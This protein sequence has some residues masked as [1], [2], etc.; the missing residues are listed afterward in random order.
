MLG[1]MMID[2]DRAATLRDEIGAE[3]FAEVVDMFIDEMEAEFA[4]LR[5]AAR[6]DRLEA[7]LH[8]LKGSALNLGF[9]ALATLCQT[10]E[11][12]AA[13]GNPGSIDLDGLCR[14]YEMSKMR[15][16]RAMEEADTSRTA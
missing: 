16:L 2:W 3:D 7:R 13:Q 5:A 15:F 12:A 10:G 6:D 11:S 14:T 1:D 4:A 9:E 8:F